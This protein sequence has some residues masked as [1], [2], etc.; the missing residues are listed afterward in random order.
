MF[1]SKF[2]GRNRLISLIL[3]LIIP[4]VFGACYYDYGMSV[5]DYDVVATFYDK[6]YSFATQKTFSIAPNIGHIVEEGEI[7]TTKKTYDDFVIEQIRSNMKIRGYQEIKD[8]TVTEPDFLIV[9]LA[10]EVDN[11]VA[12]QSY[13]W[14][15]WGGYYGG[16]WGYYPWYPSTTVYSYT[17][18]SL[19]I[20]LLDP[21]LADDTDKQL[22]VVW[23]AGVN[24]LL[25]DTSI[26]IRKRLS[27]EISQAFE[28]S[29][30]LLAPVE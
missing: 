13:P 19:I 10:A 2:T 22:P 27:S 15:G 11:Y 29:P 8:P 7:D 23:V 26:N 30:Y 6:N 1:K 25:D 16:Y 12:Y 3:L 14:W 4:V 21:K 9:C 5:S 17:S 28:Q 24:G 18:G 20:N